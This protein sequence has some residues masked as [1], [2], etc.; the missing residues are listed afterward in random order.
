[1]SIYLSHVTNRTLK[2]QLRRRIHVFY[3]LPKFAMLIKMS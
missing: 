3:L 2:E 1:M